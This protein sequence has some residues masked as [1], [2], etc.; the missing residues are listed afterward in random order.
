MFLANPFTSDIHM[1][2]MHCNAAFSKG[3]IKIVTIMIIFQF[4]T[5]YYETKKNKFSNMTVPIFYDMIAD[6]QNSF[7]LG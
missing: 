1:E 2:D 3:K 4:I 5:L 6:L 7:V